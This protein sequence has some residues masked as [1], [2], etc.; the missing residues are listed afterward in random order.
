MTNLLLL[1]VVYPDMA[2]L[3]SKFNRI[4]LLELINICCK[5]FS[6]HC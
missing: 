6:I 3:N 2:L 1:S 4:L 5:S